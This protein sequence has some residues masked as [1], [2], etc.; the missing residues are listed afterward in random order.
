M[1][2]L[3]SFIQEIIC[4]VSWSVKSVVFILGMSELRYPFLSG[5]RGLR[6]FMM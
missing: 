1:S 3:F 2:F 5:L 6:G 4:T